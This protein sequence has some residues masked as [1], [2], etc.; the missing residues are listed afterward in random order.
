M[1]SIDALIAARVPQ[2]RGHRSRRGSGLERL[3]LGPLLGSGTPDANRGPT[4]LWPTSGTRRTRR[5]SWLAVRIEFFSPSGSSSTTGASM[6]LSL[7]DG[8][9]AGTE[10]GIMAL[11]SSTT[12]DPLYVVREF[13]PPA[14]TKTYSVVIYMSAAGT[15]NISGGA[16]GVGTRF[17][18]FIRVS[19][20]A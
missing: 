8:G 17:P 5:S 7:A 15:G 3:D 19:K 9:P 16:G 18:S 13:T 4:S 11:V 14:A 6:F 10:V 12:N 20:A 1:D 2:A